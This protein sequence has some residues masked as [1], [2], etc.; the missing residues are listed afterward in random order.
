M[1]T[2]QLKIATIILALCLS[3]GTNGFAAWGRGNVNEKIDELKTLIEHHANVAKKE[4]KDLATEIGKLSED[5]E[6]IKLNQADMLQRVEALEAALSI[7]D[8][9]LGETLFNLNQITQNIKT[10]N[11][12]IEA[13]G[14]KLFPEES[15][16]QPENAMDSPN[17]VFN[18]A[19]S[20]FI[21]EKYDLAIDG[22]R[23]FIQTFPDHP[24]ANEAQYQIGDCY[25]SQGKF[26]EAVAEFRKVLEN[27]P[28]GSKYLDAMLKIGL[29]FY[30]QKKYEDAKGVF[31]R[32]IKEHPKTQQA[33]LA[34]EKLKV[35]EKK[36]K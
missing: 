4:R 12:R 1:K 20:D 32:I 36:L 17:E 35:V 5:L 15:L 33:R 23:N 27:Y 10:L 16:G 7:L 2:K 22:F 30:N 25:Y 19:H 24:R 29:S 11:S 3:F 34:G 9:R 28:E 14:R 6:T 31:E 21:K 13:I 18:M 8:G 26:T